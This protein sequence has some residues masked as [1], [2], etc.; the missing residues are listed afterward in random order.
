L[1]YLFAIGVE[2]CGTTSLD[3]ALRQS[4]HF[5]C[6]KKK[7]AGFFARHFDKGAGFH[8]RLYRRPFMGFDGYIV[9][10][11]PSYFRKPNVLVRLAE[12]D[13]EKKFIICL[14]CPF[15]RAWSHYVHDLRIHYSLGDRSDYFR[16]QIDVSFSGFFKDR[17]QYYFTKYSRL[18][19][20]VFETFGKK[21]CHVVIF[22][23]LIDDWPQVSGKLDAFLGF[24]SP[25]V[26]A[27][28][29]PHANQAQ[30][31]PYIYD[32]IT[33]RNGEITAVQK[34][35]GRDFKLK[36][37]SGQQLENALAI[38]DSY[39]LELSEELSGEICDW[40]GED[41]RSLEEMLARD[42]DKWL[43]PRTMKVNF[44]MMDDVN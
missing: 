41:V 7:E 27:L 1:K 29:L 37:L 32:H 17:K 20:N 9:D 2:K 43:L 33:H 23:D 19:E 24:E 44:D 30:K 35:R 42:L 28:Q 16:K 21:N 12:L 13:S 8:Q 14:R 39:E 38:Q 18:V 40:F 6:P 4:K 10:F 11:T 31:V 5:N 25:V 15:R 26:R 22:E 3:S 34:R 36:K